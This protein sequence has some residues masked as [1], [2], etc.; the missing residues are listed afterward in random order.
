MLKTNKGNIDPFNYHVS[1]CVKNSFKKLRKH[2]IDSN[3]D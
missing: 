3:Y 1:N 2:K